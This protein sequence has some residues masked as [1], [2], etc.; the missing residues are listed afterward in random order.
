MYFLPRWSEYRLN[1]N[2]FIVTNQGFQDLTGRLRLPVT[3]SVRFLDAVHTSVMD[4]AP[5]VLGNQEGEHKDEDE[6]ENLCI[7]RVN[8]IIARPNF[9]L[10]Y[11]YSF[12]D[13]FFPS[14]DFVLKIF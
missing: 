12:K 7:W 10:F 13:H 8:L 9:I 11:F 14:D 1:S 4:I 5:L 2:Q 6:P 3:A